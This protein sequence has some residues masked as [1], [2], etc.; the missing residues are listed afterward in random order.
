VIIA[1]PL[2]VNENFEYLNMDESR[3]LKQVEDAVAGFDPDIV[4][5]SA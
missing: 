4:G 3:Y 2:S 5:V 1:N